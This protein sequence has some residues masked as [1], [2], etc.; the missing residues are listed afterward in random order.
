MSTDVLHEFGKHPDWNESFYFNFY[1]RKND[2]F[3]FMRIGLKPNM[4]EKNAFCF[5]MMPDGSLLGMRGQDPVSDMEL[6]VGKLRFDRIVPEKKWH[7][8]FSGTMERHVEK[9]A[10][11]EQ[12]SFAVDFESLNEVFDYR[13]CVKG[14]GEKISE[15]I[16][17]EH[18]EQFGRASGRLN[19]GAIEYILDGLGERDHSWGIRDWSAPKMWI[20]LT[21]QF[22]RKLALNVTKLTMD[23]G[24]VDAG[25][26]H[27]DGNN[28]PLARADI[29]TEWDAGRNPKR[30]E[31]TLEDKR[32][33][34]HSVQSDVMRQAIVPFVG[35]NGKM[36]SLMHE[37]LARY[38]MGSEVGYGVAEYLIRTT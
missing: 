32:G 19:V 14:I 11:P 13:E 7:L 23:A 1:D 3:A 6:Q 4:N 5:F 27:I 31:M 30:L 35:A 21:C 22:S 2:A 26:I 24:D 33:R 38:T 28:I 17:S 9:I 10:T 18:F 20:W 25:F 29:H 37:A 12:V 36:V 8:S 15:A 16:A 34:L